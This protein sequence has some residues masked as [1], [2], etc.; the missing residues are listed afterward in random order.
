MYDRWDGS[1]TKIIIV[2]TID[3]GIG[4]ET[5]FMRAMAPCQIVIDEKPGSAPPLN[6][7]VVQTA[8]GRER[9]VCA[10]PLQYHRKSG[11]RLLK[12]RWPKQTFVPGKGR[13]KVV[14]DML[15]NDMGIAGRERVERLRG[16]RV[17]N[18]IN[19]VGVRSLHP[20]VDLQSKPRCVAFVD[21]V[22]DACG[23][24]L[25]VIVARVSDTLTIGAAVAI[26]GNCHRRTIRIK[27]QP[28]TA[29][30]IPRVFP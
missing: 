16:N 4:T 13:I 10:D 29:S 19:G 3:A 1:L 9:S 11:K 18:G 7:G 22:I 15:R 12:I 23:L 24:H 26:V 8:Y 6:P 27:R 14:H 30:G 5:E 21:I 25:L 28:R 17:E 2:Q 20:R